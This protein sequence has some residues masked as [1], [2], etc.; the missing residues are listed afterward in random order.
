MVVLTTLTAA[1]S[2]GMR[3]AAADGAPAGEV[4]SRMRA[5]ILG[6][7]S[8]RVTELMLRNDADGAGAETMRIEMTFVAPDRL[9]KVSDGGPLREITIIGATQ[10]AKDPTNGTWL[11]APYTLSALTNAAPMMASDLAFTDLPDRRDGND[12]VGELEVDGAPKP[13]A[14]PDRSSSDHMTCTYDKATFRPRTCVMVLPTRG[15]AT[16]T[17]A[18]WND[19][20]NVIEGPP[21]KEAR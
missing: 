15:T 2:T 6:A 16:F 1:L 12:T 18:G 17:Y 9:R 20:A 19:P 7:A 11:Y 14:Q 4:Q 8:F 21:I 5:A 10:Y 3:A 13:G